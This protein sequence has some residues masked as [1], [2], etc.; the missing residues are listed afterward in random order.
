MYNKGGFITIDKSTED[1][2]EMSSK[3]VES[4]TKKDYDSILPAVSLN[5]QFA[6]KA[7][8]ATDEI[9]KFSDRII[10]SCEKVMAKN[11]DE[12]GLSKSDISDLRKF[13]L[14]VQKLTNFIIV[15]AYST[16]LNASKVALSYLYKS[17]KVTDKETEKK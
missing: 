10:K 13:I 4:C 3:E 9:N 14:G 8:T 17:A 2:K 1:E 6:E 15:E 11:N 12:K 7:K 16:K 5:I